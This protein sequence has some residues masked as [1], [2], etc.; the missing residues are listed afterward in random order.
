MGLHVKTLVVTAFQSNA[1]VVWHDAT[2]EAV[3]I[4]PGGEPERILEY[5]KGRQVRYILL[6]HADTDHVGA[7]PEV[8]LATGAPVC[9]HPAEADWLVHLGRPLGLGAA[10]AP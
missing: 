10:L 9:V 3:V 5:V 6:T 4:D 7:V 8:R 1:Y 2:G